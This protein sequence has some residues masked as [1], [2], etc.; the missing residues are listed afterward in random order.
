MEN[1]CE[2]PANS[3]EFLGCS[4]GE[5]LARKDV[6]ELAAWAESEVPACDDPADYPKADLKMLAVAETLRRLLVEQD[7]DLADGER[8]RAMARRYMDERDAAEARALA[9]EGE[10][11]R[12]RK[13][14]KNALVAITD[15]IL[16]ARSIEDAENWTIIWD[17]ARAALTPTGGENE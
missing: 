2:R 1:E 10:R 14:L 8:F 9:A 7:R 5:P 4:V 11:D 3:G 13:A 12:L 17:A 15:A 16:R 6:L